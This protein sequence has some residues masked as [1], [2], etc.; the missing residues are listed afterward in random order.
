MHTEKGISLPTGYRPDPVPAPVD[1]AEL[2][3]GTSQNWAEWTYDWHPSSPFRAFT[4]FRY[5]FPARG[6]SHPSMADAWLTPLHPDD[7]FT[8]ETLG[9]VADLWHRMVENY[10]PNAEWGTR[11]VASR[12]TS[13]IENFSRADINGD[14]QDPLYAYPTF[15][16]TLEV[17]TLLPP[18]G[19]KWLF[20]RAQA[21][22]IKNGR[23]DTEVTIFDSDLELVALSHQVSFI[24]DLSHGA[25]KPKDL[26]AGK[27]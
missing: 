2:A 15:S 4:H 20:V 8:A 18:E 27:L 26:K 10:R 11:M 16:M 6:V 9:C 12:A 1:V 21:K 17:K 13:I 22:Q 7:A 19:V 3:K 25:R 24:V 23:M 5:F 14:S